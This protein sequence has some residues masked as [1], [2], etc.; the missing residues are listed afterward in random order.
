[1][2]LIEETKVPDTAF[3]VAALRDHL[4][5]G[6]GFADDA[7]QDAVLLPILKAAVA[8]IEAETAKVLLSR[9]YRYAVAAWRDL[10]RQSLP[11]APVTAVVSLAVT[12]MGGGEEVAPSEAYRLVPDRHRPDVM[13]LGWALPTIPVGGTAEIVFDAGFGDDWSDVP[14]D[15]AQAVMLLAAHY[16]TNRSASGDRAHPLPQGVA[17]LVQPWKRVSL[18]GGR[19]R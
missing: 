19:G 15:L 1:M 2:M 14:A 12:D 7:A 5:L 3:P 4:Q 9:R 17:H 10:A 8:K 16:H 11:V 18:F 6:R 13:W